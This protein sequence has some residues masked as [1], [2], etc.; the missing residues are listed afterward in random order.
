MTRDHGQGAH[1]GAARASRNGTT[2]LPYPRRTRPTNEPACS[3][4]ADWFPLQGA[5]GSDLAS[6][7]PVARWE[8]FAGSNERARPRRAGNKAPRHNPNLQSHLVT[9][10]FPM[11]LDAEW[12]FE[13]RVKELPRCGGAFR[14]A[15]PAFPR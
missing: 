8:A 6:S 11:F 10:R 13:D 2:T 15:V 3:T 5:P 7:V 14:G 1:R 9:A 4:I 12:R